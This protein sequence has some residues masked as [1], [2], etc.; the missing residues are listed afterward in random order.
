[1]HLT[2]IHERAFLASEPFLDTFVL[3]NV[4]QIHDGIK[5]FRI[6]SRFSKLEVLWISESQISSLPSPLFHPSNGV[7]KKLESISIHE[8]T[9]LTEIAGNTFQGLPL[10]REIVLHDDGIKRIGKQAF[11]SS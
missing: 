10:L 5:L 2:Y 7:M 4:P 1:P 11:T 8:N 3:V 6:V 9:G